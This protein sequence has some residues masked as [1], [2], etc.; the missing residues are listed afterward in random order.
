MVTFVAKSEI[1]NPQYFNPAKYHDKIF[2]F[3]TNIVICEHTST[4]CAQ[5]LREFALETGFKSE[6]INS[7]ATPWCIANDDT[8]KWFAQMY[9]ERIEKSRNLMDNVYKK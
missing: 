3:F 6:D 1:Q 5:K 7:T 4:I 9:M 2:E 8:R